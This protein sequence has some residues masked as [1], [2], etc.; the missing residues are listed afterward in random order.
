MLQLDV[1]GYLYVRQMATHSANKT[2]KKLGVLH[3]LNM[4]DVSRL[5]LLGLRVVQLP[6]KLIFSINPS[7]KLGIE[8][9]KYL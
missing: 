1:H 4:A 7:N 5:L 8:N 2:F 6:H 9:S 3:F